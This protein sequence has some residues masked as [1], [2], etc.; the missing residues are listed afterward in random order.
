[1]HHGVDLRGADHLADARIA[2]VHGH[3]LE[4]AG[5]LTGR[6]GVHPQH[7]VDVRVGGEP[8]GQQATE[9]VRD[10]GH[11][12]DGGDDVG[13][14]ATPMNRSLQE[15]RPGETVADPGAT[16]PANC[17]RVVGGYL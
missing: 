12:D 3:V 1:V 11:E 2:D 8:G 5:Q 4:A 14:H 10:P 7:P 16:V 6:A 17:D 15:I 9:L 13:R